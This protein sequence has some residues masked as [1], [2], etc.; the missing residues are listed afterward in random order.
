MI[1]L[2][3]VPLL[4]AAALVFIVLPR[5]A[6][7][8]WNDDWSLRRAVTIDTSATGA[9]I[10]EPIGRLPLLIRL[11]DGN[12]TFGEAGEAGNDLRIIAGDDETPLNFHIEQ[13]DPL[14]GQG[15]LWVDVPDLKPGAKTPLWLYF[16]NPNAAA[17]GDAA[18]TFDSDTVAVYHFAERDGSPRDST[19]FAHHLQG[20]GRSI[21]GAVIGNGLRLD[22]T[23]RLTLPATPALAVSDAGG[24]TLS[25]WV[26]AEPSAPHGV[27]YA[28]QDNGNALVIGFE[29]GVPFVEVTKGGTTQRAQGSA[30]LPPGGWHQLAVVAG[31]GQLTI[32]VDGEASGS[33]TAALPPL[34]GVATLGGTG[35]AEPGAATPLTGAGVEPARARPGFTGDIDEFRLSKVA[36]PAGFIRA[37]FASEGAGATGKLVTVD[38]A[39]ETSSW[40]TGYF[41]ILIGAVT[42]DGWIVIAILMVMAVVSWMVMFDRATYLNRTAGGNTLFRRIFDQTAGHLDQLGQMT[43][44][45]LLM[46]AAGVTPAQ[47]RRL[48]SSSLFRLFCTGAKDVHA[49]VAPAG[50]ALTAVEPVAEGGAVRLPMPSHTARGLDPYA[51]AAIRARLDAGLVIEQVRLNKAMVVLTICISGGPFLGLLGTVVGVMITFAAVAAAGDVNV[52]AI[53]PGIAAALVATVAGLFVAIPALF[54]YNYFLLRIRD[55]TNDMRVFIEEFITRIAEM[56]RA[57]AAPH[58][59]AAE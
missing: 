59:L 33:L 12:F 26:K 43:P 8:W 28:R 32:F 46:H 2:S 3:A 18:A 7:A 50:Q 9:G 36:R 34:S 21:D 54:A 48:Q 6:F 10:S 57:G 30:A 45:Q 11:H 15:F 49:R 37:S 13:F 4:L 53:A 44:Q 1:R 58:S 35:G 55:I 41:A 22:G 39:S 42:L 25:V 56:H 27:L 14:L 52:N 47:E 51:I 16:G 5:P 31:A 17:G 19:A 23:T 38:A 29:Q 20:S 24:F 40:L